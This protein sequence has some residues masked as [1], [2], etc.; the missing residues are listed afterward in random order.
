MVTISSYDR[1]T[2][3]IFSIGGLESRRIQVKLTNREGLKLHYN[4]DR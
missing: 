1:T 3:A 2:S 4:G